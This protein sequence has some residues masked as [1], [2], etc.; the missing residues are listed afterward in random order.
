MALR[1]RSS[2]AWDVGRR[3]ADQTDAR[4]GGMVIGQCDSARDPT[5]NHI[6][7]HE[8]WIGLQNRFD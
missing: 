5:F 8:M 6:Q 7:I 2:A 3:C 4:N 1:A